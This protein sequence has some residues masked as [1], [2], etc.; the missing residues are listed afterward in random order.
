MIGAVLELVYKIF[1]ISGEPQMTR[2]LADELATAH[3]FDIT[4]AKTD[5]GYKPKV[6]IE[7]GLYRLEKWLQH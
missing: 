4:A 3:W 2:F 7:E 1:K 6:S 5:L